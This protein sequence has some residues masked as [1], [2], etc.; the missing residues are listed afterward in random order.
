[1]A[2]QTFIH[3]TRANFLTGLILVLPVGIT[4]YIVLAIVTY[5]FSYLVGIGY[6]IGA[7]LSGG[8]DS[9]LIV[10]M[11]QSQSV[12]PVKTFTVG[13]HEST[14][15]EAIF[16]KKVAAHLGTDHTELY[17]TPGEAMDVIPSLSTI[18]YIEVRTEGHS[19]L[20]HSYGVSGLKSNRTCNIIGK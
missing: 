3:R 14:H 4:F 6:F 8:L 12:M 2:K 7:F 17:V 10:A 20:F 9:S 18:S 16:A 5:F 15:N 13:F 1:M 11:M 19:R